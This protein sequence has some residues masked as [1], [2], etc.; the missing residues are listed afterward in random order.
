MLQRATGTLKANRA[1][2]AEH[3]WEEGAVGPSRSFER[4][5]G[6]WGW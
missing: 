5:A 1:V 2:S 6:R 4:A 3:V